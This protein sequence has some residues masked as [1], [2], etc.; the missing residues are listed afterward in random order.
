MDT[1]IDRLIAKM[2]AARAHLNTVLEKVAPQV[3]I[4]PT[5][6]L[7]QVFDHI[8]GWDELVLS[9]LHAY[10]HG[11]APA[12]EVKN[13]IDRFNAESVNARNS[14]PLEQSRQAYDL[15]RQQVI[16]T[17][18]K[19]PPEMLT[20]QFPAPWGGKCTITSVVKI[21]VSHEEEHARQIEEILMK[22]TNGA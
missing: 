5:W 15:A 20:Q 4:Y 9:S 21:F 18:R 13:G 2:Q 6:K 3:E 19:L 8:A 1:K 16:L 10:S 11:E 12:L 7:K 14:V 17:L 22:P